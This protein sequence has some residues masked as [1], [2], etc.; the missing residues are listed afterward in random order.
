MKQV[1]VLLGPTGV[2]KTG[3]SIR[4]AQLL[5]TEIISADS[6]QVYRG[7]DIG[8]AKPSIAERSGIVHHFIDIVDPSGTFSAGEYLRTVVP[9]IE[10]L[11]GQGKIPVVVGGTGLYIKAMTR[12]MFSGPSAD[13]DLRAELALKEEAAPG[14]LYAMLREADPEAASRI[15]ENDLRRII[16]ALEV[17]RKSGAGI[18][19]LQKGATEPLPYDFV[20][21][22]LT[23][24]RS[25]L[26]R[27]INERVDAMVADGL[28]EE[29]RRLLESMPSRAPLQAIGYKE[30]AQHLEGGISLDEAVG[31]IKRNSRRYAKRQ[32]I[33]FRRE[34]GIV[35]VDISGI[36]KQE[37]AFE[38]VRAELRRRLPDIPEA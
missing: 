24:E 26:Y 10:R 2:G 19:V 38:K 30:M 32:M 31:L 11:H 33:W 3:V 15:A 29:V 28:A 21:I 7:M 9:V 8:T 12:G 16:R 13:E 4:L 14:T 17:F 27:I 35:W 34:P 20:K 1:I 36:T 37:E 6:M 22:G 23:R 18:S 5:R 25:E